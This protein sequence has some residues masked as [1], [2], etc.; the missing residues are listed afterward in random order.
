[1]QLSRENTTRRAYIPCPRPLPFLLVGDALICP[2][3]R[4]PRGALQPAQATQLAAARE[5]V[6][7]AAR[8]GPLPGM[9]WIRDGG[10][11][12]MADPGGSWLARK[13]HDGQTVAARA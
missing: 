10:I 4:R 5:I 7:L 1:M 11:I 6:A 13:M 12:A 3:P 8:A 9:A 2:W